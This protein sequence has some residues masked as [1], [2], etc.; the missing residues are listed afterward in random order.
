MGVMAQTTYKSWEL[1]LQVPVINGLKRAPFPRIPRVKRRH[2]G[3]SDEAARV[4]FGTFGMLGG[5]PQSGTPPAVKG[6]Y[7]STYSPEI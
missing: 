1:I 3:G 6:S 2:P 4:G 7:K 5:S